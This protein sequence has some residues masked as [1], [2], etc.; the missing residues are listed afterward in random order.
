[1]STPAPTPRSRAALQRG[2]SLL[3]AQRQ[4]LVDGDLLRLDSLSHELNGWLAALARDP[5]SL[6]IAAGELRP[7]L[8]ALQINAAL[9]AS[10]SAQATRALEALTTGSE[11]TYDASGRPALV[12]GGGSLFSA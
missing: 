6:S 2:R 4:A 12:S 9:V 3:E 1:M 7:V 5:Q 10:A 11:Q 8:G